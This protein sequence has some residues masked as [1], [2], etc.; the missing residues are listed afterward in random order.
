M[1]EWFPHPSFWVNFL[2]KCESFVQSRAQLPRDSF[3]MPCIRDYLRRW[4]FQNSVKSKTEH[5]IA[6]WIFFRRLCR[7]TK[8][9][10]TGN[11]DD[12]LFILA[13]LKFNKGPTLKLS[14]SFLSFLKLC[15]AL[16]ENKVA[17]TEEWMRRRAHFTGVTKRNWHMIQIYY[18]QSS[19]GVVVKLGLLS[20]WHF[21][22]IIK[23]L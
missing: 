9:L 3:T 8:A 15:F 16:T 14:V 1:T 10:V 5:S 21:H 20:E 23:L 13:G 22:Y 6:F 17:A 4:H 7:R 11:R 19:S 12:N 18:V 2:V